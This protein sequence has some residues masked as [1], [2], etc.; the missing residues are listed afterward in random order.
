M[1]LGSK[2]G[3]GA[4]KW[5]ADENPRGDGAINL[6]STVPLS[7]IK[8]GGLY[9]RRD[10]V[11][12]RF[13]YCEGNAGVCCLLGAYYLA[14]PARCSRPD[15]RGDLAGQRE[16]LRSHS[17]QHII[18]TPFVWF[19]RRMAHRPTRRAFRVAGIAR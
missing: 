14:T 1:S 18:E 7:K 19:E 2:G 12:P 5:W 15:R 13:S 16:A 9:I 8:I 11:I 3:G 17:A 10:T 6:V 4:G